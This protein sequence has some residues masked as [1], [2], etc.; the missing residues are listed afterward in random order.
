[1]RVRFCWCGW[2]HAYGH[3]RASRLVGFAVLRARVRV[4]VASE[5]IAVSRKPLRSGR[6]VGSHYATHETEHHETEHHETQ[7]QH[8]HAPQE[9]AA[10][11][12]AGAD[13]GTAD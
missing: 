9:A 4:R 13:G 7:H 2:M 1:M 6:S 10:R 11:S 8:Q 12:A 5:A 3:V